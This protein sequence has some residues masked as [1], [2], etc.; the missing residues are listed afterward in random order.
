MNLSIPA[1]NGD[2]DHRHFPVV[3][4]LLQHVNLL[5]VARSGKV[6]NKTRMPTHGWEW[7]AMLRTMARSE[8]A[9]KLISKLAREMDK[10]TRRLNH[11]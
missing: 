4:R 1:L 6:Q 11:Q 5:T 8:S 9:G 2:P 10:T 3:S 7:H